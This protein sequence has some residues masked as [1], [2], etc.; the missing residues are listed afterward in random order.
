MN[1]RFTGWFARGAIAE[2]IRGQGPHF[3]PSSDDPQEHDRILAIGQL[4][5]WATDTD[6]PRKAAIGIEEAI[7]ESLADEDARAA[8]DIA[9]CYFIVADGR[10]VSLPIDW[11]TIRPSLQTAL[12]SHLD[13]EA[14]VASRVMARIESLGYSER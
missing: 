2:A 1:A 8:F 4:L 14:E 3:V 12:D 9:W 7:A 13:A 10:S 6:R 5:R 11:P